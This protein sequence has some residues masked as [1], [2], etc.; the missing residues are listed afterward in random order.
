MP[1]MRTC[2]ENKLD[3]REITL[4]MTN[5][6]HIKSRNPWENQKLQSRDQRLKGQK[7]HADFWPTILVCQKETELAVY[8]DSS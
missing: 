7:P 4:L 2:Q 5:M 3:L 8:F 6:F 1:F